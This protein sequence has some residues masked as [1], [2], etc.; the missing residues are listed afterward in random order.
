MLVHEFLEKSADLQP[1]KVALIC[2]SQEYTY[3]EIDN[4]ANQV[5]NALVSNRIKVGDRILLHL[6][7]CIELVTGIFGVLKAGGI[8]IVVNSSTK[9][10]KLCYIANNCQA[11][12]IFCSGH[13][14]I[15]NRDALRYVPTFN[16]FL[17]PSINKQEIDDPDILTFDEIH[18][19]YYPRCPTHINK[20][21]DLACLVYTS[22]STGKSKG[23]MC[24]HR[25]VD[26]VSS[27]IIQYL[28][29]ESDDIV[30]NVLPLSFD[31]GLYQLLMTFKFGGTLVL[32][33]GFVYPAAVLKKMEESNV[34]GF[35]GVPT[36]FNMLLQMD[37]S[38][39]DLSSLRYITNTAA[40]L[41]P[42]YIVELIKKFPWVKIF[43]MYGLTE[44]KR[45]LYLPPELLN[46]RPDSVGIPI[47]GT[48][49]WIEDEEGNHLGPGQVGELVVSGRHVMRGY[50]DDP[51]ATNKRYKLGPSQHDRLCYTGDLFKMDEEGYLYFVSRTDDIIK[52]KGEK[53]APKEVES[54]LYSM[55]E[56]EET[57][58]IGIPD[59][60]LGEAVKAF[61][62]P[63]TDTMTVKEVLLYC[64]EH[65]EDFMVPKT[66]QF[67]KSLPKT[68]SGKVKK[69]VLS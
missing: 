66:V 42:S 19:D 23:V 28:E 54:I 60:I 38:A 36:I 13:L 12:A 48:E 1:D 29:N 55:D 62:V 59:P 3:R 64:R 15:E 27:S 46:T 67:C 43:S 65:L 40:A 45:T 26:F 44:T 10:D 68:P 31:Y 69:T 2:G 18:A 14:Y 6:P 41:P 37:L 53:V 51:V 16:Q 56:V 34:T 22:G 17:V 7:S 4:R 24:E 32:E 57:A 61:I 47:P 35:P 52:T 5:A 39:Y 58:V 30:I 9:I 8:F 49:V 50:W 21:D 33:R 25:N 63:K 20:D 11:S